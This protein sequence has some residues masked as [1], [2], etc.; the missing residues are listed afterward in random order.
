MKQRWEWKE[1]EAAME[2]W[3]GAVMEAR[4]VA[5]G[6]AHGVGSGELGGGNAHGVTDALEL[7]WG[8]TS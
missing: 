5:V 6:A 7:W 4:A 2:V 3:N 1:A 8:C